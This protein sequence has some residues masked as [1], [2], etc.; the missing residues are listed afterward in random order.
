MLLAV[1]LEEAIVVQTHHLSLQSILTPEMHLGPTE[2]RAQRATVTVL[3]K[4]VIIWFRKLYQI[5]NW[6]QYLLLNL[7][8]E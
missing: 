4:D 2:V 3:L 5:C 6:K 1:H 7:D 8:K